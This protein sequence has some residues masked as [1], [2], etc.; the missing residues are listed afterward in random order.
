M[1]V[2]IGSVN[3]LQH[4]CMHATINL[5]NLSHASNLSHVWQRWPPQINGNNNI[6]SSKVLLLCEWFKKCNLFEV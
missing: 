2:E 6:S 1:A 4:A 5:S 3:H